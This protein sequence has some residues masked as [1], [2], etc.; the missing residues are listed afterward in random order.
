MSDTTICRMPTDEMLGALYPLTSYAFHSSPPFPD[1]EEWQETVRQREGV[2]YFALF[3]DDVAVAT[4]ASTAMTQQVRGA[5]YHAGGVWGVV[6]HPAARRNGYSK[7][8]MARLLDEDRE[9]GRP[10]S[11]LYPFRESF[12]ERLGY[13]TFPVPR[14]AKLT[15][16]SLLHLLEKD[17]DGQVELML[18]GDGYDTYRD[19]LYRLQRRVHGMGIFVHGQKAQVQ[20]HNRSW[21]ALAKVGGEPVGLMLYELKGEE[22]TKFT[23]RAYRFYYDTSQA[24]YLLLQWIARHVDQA[25]EVEIWLPPFELPETWLADIRVTSESQIRAP[26]GRIVDVANIGG[27][28]TGPGRFSAC[29]TD[30]ICPWNAGVW[31]FETA[32]GVLRVSATDAA[33]CDLTIQ[34][35]AALIYGTHDPGDFAIR[36]WGNPSSEVQAVMRSMFPPRLPYLHEYF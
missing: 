25:N 7:R 27:M 2:T 9:A 30:P 3:E 20:K 28:L 32:D 1:K 23:L 14:T 34:A 17:L 29:I 4:V 16:S 5:N 26:M 8:L 22:V 13:V 11:C 12:Y 18:I 6:T 19:Y 33:D 21:L 15:P 31:Q 10:L 24:K 35:L 36:G